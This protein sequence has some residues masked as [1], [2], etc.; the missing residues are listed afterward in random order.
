MV[1][2]GQ[3]VHLRTKPAKEAE[4]AKFLDDALQVDALAA[5]VT[6]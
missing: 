1:R 5:K 2:V 6:T 3:L 4:M